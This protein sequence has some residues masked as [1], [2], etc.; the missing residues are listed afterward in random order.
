MRKVQYTVEELTC[1][2]CG[3]VAVNANGLRGHRQFKHGVRPSGAQLPL[4]KQ[5]LLVSESKLEQL[6]DERFSVISEQV[7]ALSGELGQLAE[8]A[9]G[10][11]AAIAELQERLSAAE[12]KTIEDFSS[13][14][15]AE[16]VIPWMQGLSGEDFVRLALETGHDAQLVPATDPE[17]VGKIA[18]IMRKQE[19]EEAKVVRGRTDLPGYRY[20]ENI[21]LSVFVGEEEL[22]K[23]R[24]ELINLVAKRLSEG[25]EKLGDRAVNTM[26]IATEL[27]GNLAEIRR[28]RE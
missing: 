12:R 9:K 15:K 7:D 18:E 22:A 25:M 21:D 11:G 17:M 8:A 19:R 20:L 27:I 10:D 2:E 5:D 6:L 26:K 13:R 3:F 14:E 28:R 24:Q 4:Q 16:F 23:E 1:P